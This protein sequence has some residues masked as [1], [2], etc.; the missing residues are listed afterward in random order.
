MAGGV[1]ALGQENVVVDTA[2]ERLVKW[3][4]L[5]KELLLNLSETV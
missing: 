4:G 3:D 2:L 5:S 1:V